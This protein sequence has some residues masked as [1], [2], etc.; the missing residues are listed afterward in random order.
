[1]KLSKLFTTSLLAM[2]V[3]TGAS[4]AVAPQ[5]AS[6][7]FELALNSIDVSE[8]VEAGMQQAPEVVFD[9]ATIEAAAQGITQYYITGVTSSSKGYENISQ[10]K[11]ITDKDHSG[12]IDVYV[13]QYGYGNDNGGRL[14]G[15]SANSKQSRFLC[16]SLSNL[17]FCNPGE[18]VTGTMYLYKFNNSQGGYFTSSAYSV[19]SPFGTKSD[20]LNIR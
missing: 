18:T 20:S 14:N 13:F 16:G 1:M 6:D 19:A 2:A 15:A 5:V 17:H 11:N 3:T 10:F 8:I 12:T 9:D 4:A 7:D